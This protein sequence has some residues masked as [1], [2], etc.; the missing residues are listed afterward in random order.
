MTN[1]ANIRRF[2]DQ[3]RA[4][5]DRV[6]DQTRAAVILIAE[7]SVT[8]LVDVSPVDE[9]RSEGAGRFKGAWRVGVGSRPAPGVFPVDVSGASTI[10]AAKAELA[11]MQGVQ[12][13]FIVNDTPYG[14]D[15]ERGR[16]KQAPAGVLGRSLAILRALFARVKV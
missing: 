4:E 11:K 16:S 8:E 5:M 1:E 6:R 13:V 10:A 3:L 7:R 12:P 15:L 9:R 2:R 14:E